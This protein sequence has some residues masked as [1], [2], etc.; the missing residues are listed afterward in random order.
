MFIDYVIMDEY[1]IYMLMQWG[2]FLDYDMSFIFQFVSNVRFSDGR[3]CNEICENQYLC[4]FIRV[5]RSDVRIQYINCLGFFRSSVICNLGSILVFY[6][7][8]VFRQQ[9]NVI[10]VFIDVSFVYGSSDFEVQRLREFLN[11]RGF[12]REGV[13]LK[14]NKRLL[15]FDIGN[16]FYYF[17]C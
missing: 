16:F 6:K 2:Q 4:F 1:S 7:I 9:I 12:L 14:N 15:S 5:L 11:G 10:I 13:L 17:D 3:F 8:F